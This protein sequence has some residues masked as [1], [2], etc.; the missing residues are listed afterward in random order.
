MNAHVQTAE[1]F[2]YDVEK[3]LRAGVA[4][5]NHG[6]PIARARRGAHSVCH[7][8]E[9]AM[10]EVNSNLPDDLDHP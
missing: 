6:R 2:P 4:Q 10:N 7:H 8:S 5:G 9:V 3:L 1:C